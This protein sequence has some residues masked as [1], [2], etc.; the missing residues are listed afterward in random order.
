VYNPAQF[1]EE[2]PRVLR[3]FIAAHPLGALVAVTPEGLT[4]N[5]I[6]MMWE[7]R[8]E[9]PGC[10]RGHLARAN[11]LWQMLAPES[12]VLVIFGGADRYITPSWYPAK[13]E[14]GKVVP[15]WNYSV[16]HAHGAIR[17]FD[18]RGERL[19]LVEALTDWQEASR[20]EPWKVADAPA[21]Y[22]ELMLKN[23]VTFEIGITRLEGKFKASQHRPDE[24]R[25]SVDQALEAA[26]V[27][28][29]ARSELI[30][31]PGR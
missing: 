28:A 31:L 14:H 25:V 19:E 5:H 9:T 8:D 16:V 6:P 17:F 3:E 11:R 21:D 4:A 10:L 30:K 29:D 20:A 12:A 2:D 27:S 7:A 24:E 26:G 23:I 22:I 18:E 13:R 15:T 1:K